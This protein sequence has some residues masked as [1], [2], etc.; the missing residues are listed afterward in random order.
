[1]A[2]IGL[3]NYGQG[4]V[5]SVRNALEFLGQEVEEVSTGNELDRATHLILPGVGAF[6]AVM[7]R[8]GECDL[9]EGLLRQVREKGKWLLGICAGMQVLGSVGREFGSHPGL[10]LIEGSV[11][12]IPAGEQGLPVPHMGWN[13]LA[14][15]RPSRLFA[16]LPE[17]PCFYFVHSYELRP[18]DGGAISASCDYGGRITAGIERDNV[19]GVQFHPEKSQRDGLQLLRNFCDL[20]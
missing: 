18:D 20:N 2:S 14:L 13:E 1:M 4:N 5:A 17:H 10:G 16:E 12:L 9:A 7:K 11:D 6:A 19:F 8:L 3:I 15:H